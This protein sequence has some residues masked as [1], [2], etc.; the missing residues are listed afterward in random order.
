VTDKLRRPFKKRH[1][2][3]VSSFPVG[4]G[5]GGYHYHQQP[6]SRV[7]KYLAQAIEARS[8][9][10]D[11]TTHVHP[12][13]LCFRD[14]D[15]ERQFHE[16]F[17]VGLGGALVCCLCLLV[18]GGG[19]QALVLPRTLILLLLFLT[20]F[21]WLSVT[22][23][24]LMAARLRL[25]AW[26]LAK[27]APPLRLALALFSLIL[28]YATAQVNVFTCRVEVPCSPVIVDSLNGTTS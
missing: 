26:D 27:G 25:L 14:S 6:T 1:P 10:R 12:M 2:S 7:N 11:K 20:A 24:L 13:T 15:K 21:A 16:E 9:D 17:D 23:M 22:L 3:T 19:M 4:G 5:S 8:V 28:V 18:L